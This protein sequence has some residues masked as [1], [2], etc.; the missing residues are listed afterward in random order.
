LI[1]REQRE[2]A[3]VDPAAVFGSPEEIVDSADLS[4]EDK[5]EFLKR[6]RYDAIELNVA[7]DEGMGEES[8]PLLDRIVAALDKIDPDGRHAPG[9]RS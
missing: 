9:R 5:L 3:R 8:S 1:S 6:W 4:R 7:A 2:Q